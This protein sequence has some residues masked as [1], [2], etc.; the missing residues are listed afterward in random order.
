MIAIVVIKNFTIK[1][2]LRNRTRE[3]NPTQNQHTT[4]VKEIIQQGLIG[5]RNKRILAIGIE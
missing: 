5:R 3:I 1:F 2:G 4:Y